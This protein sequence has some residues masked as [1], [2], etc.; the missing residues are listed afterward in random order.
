MEIYFLNL[1]LPVICYRL[2][3]AGP[4]L[5]SLMM[6]HLSKLLYK[7]SKGNFHLSNLFF[8][9]KESTKDKANCL[10]R[11]KTR[12]RQALSKTEFLNKKILSPLY[13]LLSFQN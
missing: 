3:F 8:V 6:Y 11:L 13:S 9:A 5:I 2:F 1:K 7:Y 12:R 10:Q 4:L